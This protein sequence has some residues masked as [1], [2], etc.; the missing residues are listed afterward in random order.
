MTCGWLLAN[1]S[2]G[3]P[4]MGTPAVLDSEC[5]ELAARLVD[6]GSFLE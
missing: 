2:T 6:A 5:A 3:R 4:N 1:R